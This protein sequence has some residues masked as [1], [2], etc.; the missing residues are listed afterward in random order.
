MQPLSTM[1]NVD[2]LHLE[3]VDHV[4][5]ESVW[6]PRSLERAAGRP[7]LN[8]SCPGHCKD[9]KA[10]QNM[11]P[12]NMV[13]SN[14]VPSNPFIIALQDL[15]IWDGVVGRYHCWKMIWKASIYIHQLLSQW[16]G[17]GQDNWLIGSVDKCAFW[18]MGIDCRWTLCLSNDCS[19][20]HIFTCSHGCG[21]TLSNNFH[22]MNDV[23]S[24]LSFFTAMLWEK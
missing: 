22:W 6:Q 13:K 21:W 7:A 4:W 14:Q 10:V 23:S 1:Q 16:L 17:H 15:H 11:K 2:N 12:S 8:W 3:L 5:V 19:H 20:V 18:S 24:G 9:L